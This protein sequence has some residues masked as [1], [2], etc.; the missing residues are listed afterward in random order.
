MSQKVRFI[1]AADL[2]LGKTLYGITQ[3]YNDFFK[4]F[5]WLL[6]KAKDEKVDFILISGDLIDSEQKVNP[7]TLGNIIKHIQDFQSK[8]QEEMEREIPI[9]CIEGNH[10][11]PFFS[12]QTWLKLLADLG[13]IILLSGK[14][15]NKTKTI[16]FPNYSSRDNNGGKIEIKNTIIYGM[17]YFGS[18]TPELYPLIRDAIQKTDKYVILM[19]H[20]G[21]EG[22]D[23]RKKGYELTKSLRKLHNK[24]NYLALGHFHKQYSLPKAK[25]DAWIYNPGSLEVNEI[26]EYSEPHGIFLVDIFPKENNDYEV[27]S[28]LCE[29]GATENKYSIP[30]RRFLSF[31]PIDISESKSFEEA[32]VMIIKRLRKLGVPERTES[33]LDVNNLNTP[34]L[35]VSITGR[36]PYSELE[37]D[38][39]ELKKR[40]FENFEIL[41]LRLQNQVFS[42]IG[43]EIE[44]QDDW[45]FDKI[46]KEAFLSTIESEESFRPHKEEIYN[47]VLNQLKGKLTKKADY[48]V[49]KRDIDNWFSFNQDI[50]EKV[51][52]IVKLQKKAKPTPQKKAKKSKKEKKVPQKQISIDKAWGNEDFEEEFGEM[53]KFLDYD[54]EDEDLD[55]DDLIDDGELDI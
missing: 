48:A 51:K 20:F 27:K 45:D 53:K 19:M 11:T 5:D 23:K 15:D 38:L 3:R 29:N 7:S 16:D 50:L 18:S 30:N 22:Q 28:L 33:P 9:I 40:I 8:C 34:V 47:L 24:V 54:E 13:L 10:E 43:E 52:K 1:H 41:G 26:T 44:I 25:G 42:Q 17:S 49:I 55:I 35:Y 36:I 12:D 46:E 4:A 39:A 6:N 32:Q 37:V 2:H 14:Y 21:I 31:S